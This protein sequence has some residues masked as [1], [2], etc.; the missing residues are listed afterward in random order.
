MLKNLSLENFRSHQHFELEL[1]PNTVLVG[2]N[3]A[4]KSN[5][6]ESIVL[7]SHCRSY[8]EDRKANLINNGSEF[9][10]V[11]GDD[12]ELFLSK[13]PQFYMKARK[14]GVFKRL[15]EFVGILPS[16]VFSPE[17]L[18]IITGSPKERR[19]LLDI[20]ISQTSR[21]YLRALV[22]YE[23][24]R[25]QRNSLLKAIREKR[26]AVTELG[27]WNGQLVESGGKIIM[28]REKA[29]AFINNSLPEF[30]QKI[31]GDESSRL[32]LVYLKSSD[33]LEKDLERI[34]TREICEERTLIGPHKDDLRFD[35]N[36]FNMQNFASRGEI[37]SAVLALKLS[38]VG[39]LEVA[40]AGVKPILLV[41]DV[42]SEFDP[43]RRGHLGDLIL[44]Y[45]T[46]ITTAEKEQLSKELL[47][48]AKVVEL[49]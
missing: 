19:R 28:E 2:R 42:F 23:K 40:G 27:Y 3:G 10:R 5:I 18:A 8:R 33:N 20:L 43:V 48:K 14:G 11:T 7:L 35:L 46:L 45:Q 26:G 34:V 38:E 41:D 1:E 4:G 16:V 9:A 37:K 32:K 30:Y 21:E 13:N 12:L 15:T 22:E 24:I 17:T 39:Y 6:L 31:A 36:G 49:K 44:N 29:V 47:K 25:R